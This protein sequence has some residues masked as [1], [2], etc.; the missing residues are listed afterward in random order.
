MEPSGSSQSA[1][2]ALGSRDR[3]GQ[4]GRQAGRSLGKRCP[5]NW[6][7]RPHALGCPPVK[8]HREVAGTGGR[9]VRVPVKR[10]SAGAKGERRPAGH[11]EAM[12]ST[13][14]VLWKKKKKKKKQLR[15]PLRRPLMQLR[16][17]RIGKVAGWYLGVGSA[18]AG[19]RPGYIREENRTQRANLAMPAYYPHGCIYLSHLVLPVS[20]KGNAVKEP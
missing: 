13:Q 1:F 9:S 6:A 4:K 12:Q 15:G 18:R 7:P 17:P 14:A 16:V 8:L 2:C 19:R 11:A 3:E 10:R 20:A 5:F